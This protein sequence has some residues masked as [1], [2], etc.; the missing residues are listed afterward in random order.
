M[1]EAVLLL[2]NN[3][4]FRGNLRAAQVFSQ[5]EVIFNTSM[6]GYQEILTDPSYTGQIVTMTYPHI[7][8]YG[9]NSEDMESKTIHAAALIV[10]ELSKITSNWRAN[11]SLEDWLSENNIP[12]LEG[13]DTRALVKHLRDE[14]AGTGMIIPLNDD[15]SFEKHDQWLEKVS[16]L[17]LMEGLNLAKVVSTK[18][19]YKW[20]NNKKEFRYNVVAYDFGIKHNILRCMEKLDM[21]VT[22]VPYNTTAEDVLKMDPNG[23]FLSNGPGDPAAVTETIPIVKNLLGKVPIFGICLG[24]QILSLALGCKTYKLKFGHHGGNHPVMDYQTKKIEITSHNHGFAVDEESLPS[25]VRVTHRNL[26]DHTVEG[27]D[28]SEYL[29]Y[30]VQYHPEAAPGPHDAFYLFD[31]F[32]ELMNKNS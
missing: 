26:N 23:V 13:I 7:G 31:R 15:P 28:S 1:T 9:I 5:G 18:E 20:K 29:A 11:K 19:K 22:V 21:D 17:P 30:S 2:S 6:T 12:I 27:I 32:I 25:N 16:Q 3:K 4:L 8:N 14:G 24:H 10:K